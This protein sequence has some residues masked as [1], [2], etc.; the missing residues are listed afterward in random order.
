[1]IRILAFCL[2][3][4]PGIAAAREARPKPPAP[5]PVPL[6][7]PALCEA[8]IAAAEAGA[9]LPARVL[10][11]IA[12]RESGRN[13]PKTGRAR[14]W[15]WTINYAGV[16]HYYET[17]EEAIAAVKD[18]QAAGGQSIDVGC[19]QVNLLHHPAA[20]ASLEEAFD[21][22]RNAA[23]AGRFLKGLFASFGDWGPAIAAYHSRTAGKG[24][25][26][27]DQ[28]VASWRPTDP[29]V[30]ARLTLTPP[31]APTEGTVLTP[32]STQGTAAGRGTAMTAAKPGV[33]VRISSTMAYRAFATIGSVYGAFQP[34]SM[35][36]ADFAPKPG[37]PAR[38]RP[39]DLRLG[40]GGLGQSGLVVP[41][42]VIERNGR[43]EKPSV[44]KPG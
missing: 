13:D 23:Y 9:K 26:Y 3:A 44:R 6:T 10:A 25:A 5:P 28:V 12:L 27:R 14:P 35:A 22:R 16:G 19:M 18:I 11:A 2:L 36:Y 7:P 39:L 43:A 33:A 24:E 21:P 37:K 29:A 20:F 8:A 4:L 1:M 34:V 38:G 30:L 41:K 31:P 17:P 32:V 15:P 40:G 42:G